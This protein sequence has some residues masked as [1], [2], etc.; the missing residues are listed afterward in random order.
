MQVSIDSEIN[1]VCFDGTK[2]GVETSMQQNCSSI[3][4]TRSSTSKNYTEMR[5]GWDNGGNNF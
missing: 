4:R 3:F 5:E 1:M 2:H